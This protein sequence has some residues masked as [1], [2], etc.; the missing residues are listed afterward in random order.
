MKRDNKDAQK[1]LVTNADEKRAAESD[2]DG[3]IFG[4]TLQNQPINTIFR[5]NSKRNSKKK[6]MHRLE[7]QYG[8]IRAVTTAPKLDAAAAQMF[9]YLIYI[10]ANTPNHDNNDTVVITLSDYM[11]DFKK[12][13]RRSARRAIVKNLD[14]L[15]N[16][17]YEYYGGYKDDKYNPQ[18]RGY[19][20]LFNYAYNRRGTFIV[21]WDNDFYNHFLLN[22]AMPMPHYQYNFTL[23]PYKEATSLYILRA[24]EENKRKNAGNPSRQNWIKVSTLLEYIRSLK[25]AEQLRQKGDRHYYERIIEPIYKAVERLANPRDKERPLKSY[26]FTSGSGKDKK[27]LELGDN[28]VD[29]NL[30][31]NAN[32]EVEWN[33]YPDNLLKQWN[34]T[35]KSK[36]KKKSKNKP[37]SNTK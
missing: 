5:V 12:T 29:Y 20:H 9:D 28:N 15:F 13:D 21:K 10:Y 1:K 19:I 23:N 11:R 25:P 35:Q 31:I 33:N 34:K 17:H 26:C 27:L 36:N 18:W 16:T 32:L 14:A 37:K 2:I 7:I 3:A 8:A 6:P 30:F 24:L 4:I 22:H